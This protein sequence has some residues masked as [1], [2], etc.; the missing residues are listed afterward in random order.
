[1]TKCSTPVP[2][3]RQSGFISVIYKAYKI[4]KDLNVLSKC[5]LP[6]RDSPAPPGDLNYSCTPSNGPQIRGEDFR[7]QQHKCKYVWHCKQRSWEV[8]WRLPGQVLTYHPAQLYHR[9]LEGRP[10]EGELRA[11]GADAG[12]EKVMDST[13]TYGASIFCAG[14]FRHFRT[15]SEPVSGDRR[16]R[17]VFKQPTCKWS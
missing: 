9:D 17:W 15:G 10:R 5:V 16:C 12:R 1:M 7:S 6:H 11:Q 3:I 8:L 4:L 2:A 14:I 13:K